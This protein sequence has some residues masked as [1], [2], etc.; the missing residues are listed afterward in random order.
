MWVDN[1][2]WAFGGLFSLH[3]PRF[4]CYNHK[5]FEKRGKEMMMWFFSSPFGCGE[6]CPQYKFELRAAF[7][8]FSPCPNRLPDKDLFLMFSS[9]THACLYAV[10]W[11]KQN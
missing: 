2:F 4:R 9:M 7:S 5:I 10:I 11:M 8:T 1:V 6:N 3:I